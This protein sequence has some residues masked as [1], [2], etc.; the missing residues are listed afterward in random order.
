MESERGGPDVSLR[1]YIE[2]LVEVVRRD[3]LTRNEAERRAMELALQVVQQRIDNLAQYREQI[4]AELAA[5]EVSQRRAVDLALKNLEHRLDG[6][7]L[8]R[9]QIREERHEFVRTDT[10]RW[11]II[12]L[13]AVFG[14]VIAAMG[15]IVR[16]H[17]G[18]P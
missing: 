10:L 14:T 6:M 2:T 9:E 3:L 1:E 16:G 11:I 4:H 15:L 18:A 17:A 7:N 8:F 12:M 13:L 5:S